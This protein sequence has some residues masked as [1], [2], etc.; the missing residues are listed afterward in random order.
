ML[1]MICITAGKD[2]P[3]VE[4]AT[5]LLLGN[6]KKGQLINVSRRGQGPS[7]GL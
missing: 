2:W 5:Y 1:R 3:E 6:L 4:T 7:A